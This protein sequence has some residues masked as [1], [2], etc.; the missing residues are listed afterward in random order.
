MK[1][2][3]VY[4]NKETGQISEILNNKKEG[5]RNYIESNNKEVSKFIMGE[6]STNNYIVAYC[7]NKYQLIKKDNIIRLRKP[8]NR[9]YK[10]PQQKSITNDLI[11]VSYPDN[12]LEISLNI[13]NIT[14]LF[15][16]DFRKEV[17][18]EKGS[19]IRIYL[20]DKKNNEIAQ[21]LILD[22]QKILNEGQIFLELNK[23]INIDDINFYTY[24]V[25]E[26]YSWY[27]GTEKYISPIKEKIQFDIQKVTENIN[28]KD[29]TYHLIISQDEKGFYIQNHIDNIKLVRIFND[30]TFYIVDK[31][32]SHILHEKFILSK[33]SFEKREK[34]I[35]LDLK[36]Q[37]L[38]DKSILYNHKYI[39]VLKD[40][41]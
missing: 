35:R 39:S 41:I 1:K 8:N 31:H 26:N 16:T 25:F 14:P 11:I 37:N 20:K 21:E 7:K 38:N 36:T 30:I 40:I 4:Y 2:R 13:S 19:E 18:F 27:K 22:A 32:D 5:Q 28:K 34:I 12:T 3:Y 17:K 33:E 6:E 10:I 29:V 24:R 9:L 23:N 15:Q